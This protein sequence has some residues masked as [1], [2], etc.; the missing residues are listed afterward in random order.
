MKNK[1]FIP[2]TIHVGYNNRNDTYT[3]KLAYVIYTDTK[4]VKRKETSW[5]SWRSKDITPDDHTNEPMSGFVLNKG[6]GGGKQ[7]YG[8]NA[9]NEYIR[10]YDPRG[11]EFEIS[12]ANLLFILQECTSTKGKGL[13]G[14]FIYA[15]DGKEL[16]LLPTSSQEYIDCTS[17]TKLQD[18]KITAKDM[19]VGREY[20][21]KKGETLIYMGRGLYHETDSWAVST[22]IKSVKDH[23]YATPKTN[24]GDDQTKYEFLRKSGFTHLAKCVNEEEYGDFP[25]VLA[26]F[27]M[28]PH[29]SELVGVELVEKIRTIR[30]VKWV[31]GERVYYD[32][33]VNSFHKKIDE[34]TYGEY[35]IEKYY[36]NVINTVIN[37]KERHKESFYICQQAIITIGDDLTVT[38][39]STTH[40]RVGYGYQHK[41][42]KMEELVESEDTNPEDLGYGSLCLVTSEGVKINL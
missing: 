22:Y 30:S 29:L 4:G 12:V 13:E 36:P 3:G 41:P 23:V 9:R 27:Q 8:W 31:D 24:N 10:V 37:H 38:K 28:T 17:F 15:W 1:M 6:V 32:R 42:R 34:N 26:D 16:V 35:S 20:L 7:S 21:N 11:F 18:M 14:D 25:S 40:K 2:K 19:K 39:E 5:E 33:R